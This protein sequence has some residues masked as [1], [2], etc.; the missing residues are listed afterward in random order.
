MAYF[1]FF[2]DIENK[3][4]TI[5]GGGIVAARK[6][7]ML[8][9]FGCNVTVISPFFCQ[10]IQQIE[11]IKLINRKIELTDFENSFFVIAAT[12]DT[13]VNAEISSFCRSKNILV[14]VVDVMEECS[15]IFPSI[16]KNKTIV[17]GVT[18]SG[19]SPQ[20]SSLVRKTIAKNVPNYYGDTAERLGNL[21]PRIKEE[22]S[23]QLKRKEVLSLILEEMLKTENKISDEEIENIIRGQK[24]EN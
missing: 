8:I 3:N 11:G 1:P 7:E 5:A 10:E 9:Q 22:I 13:Q 17:A 6:A 18:T 14:N 19:K 15:F 21:R 24:N 23:N 2:I 12:N 4:C 20:V 16:Y